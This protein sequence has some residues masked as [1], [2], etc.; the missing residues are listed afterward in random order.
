VPG[1]VDA[2]IGALIGGPG[3]CL[4]AALFV[5]PFAMEENLPAP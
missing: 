2:L 5:M 3:N 4:G 1:A